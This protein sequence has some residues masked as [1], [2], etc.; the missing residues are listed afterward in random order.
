MVPGMVRAMWD[1]YVETLSGPVAAA[2]VGVDRRTAFNWIDS[3]GGVLRR[4]GRHPTG[5]RLSEDRC[6][7]EAGLAV[8]ETQASIAEPYRVREVH[9]ATRG[10][11]G[12]P[13]KVLRQAGRRSRPA[14][15]A[16]RRA[17]WPATPSCGAGRGGSG[18]RYS[19]QQ[20][21]ARLRPRLPRDDPEMWVHHNTIYESLYIQARG[22]AR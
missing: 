9:S 15:G 10:S 3:C 2:W 8:K 20:I 5:K 4:Q 6:A 16:P 12:R 13:R 19:P 14:A 22:P 21:A 1:K 11:V 17:S 7:I 18:K